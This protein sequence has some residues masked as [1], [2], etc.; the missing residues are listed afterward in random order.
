MRLV[1]LLAAGKSVI[2]LRGQGSPYRLTDQR[3]L[4]RFDT[5]PH[6]HC[7]VAKPAGL[8]SSEAGPSE[9][10]PV[11]VGPAASEPTPAS[12]AGTWA[13]GAR[14]SWLSRARRWLAGRLGRLWARA[15]PKPK[16]PAIRRF[17][18][19]PVQG[20]LTLDRVKVVRNDLSDADLQFVQLR[21]QAKASPTLPGLEASLPSELGEV[22]KPARLSGAHQT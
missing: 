15:E 6:W 1:K 18:P 10:P 17:E 13:P 21:S 22:G 19:P 16:S 3:L 7:P 5:E 4:P 20:E 12:P 9:P 11:A 2:G 14:Q 8:S